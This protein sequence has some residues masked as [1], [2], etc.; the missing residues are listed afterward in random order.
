[1]VAGVSGSVWAVEE[2]VETRAPS[3]K[4]YHEWDHTMQVLLLGWG[5]AAAIWA[6]QQ[7]LQK[8]Y[9]EFRIVLVPRDFK[10]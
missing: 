4:P 2:L 10:L 9:S 8:T 7:S 6:C 3:Q 1:M 5:V